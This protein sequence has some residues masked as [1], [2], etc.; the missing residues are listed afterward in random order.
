M[1]VSVRSSSLQRQ[2]RRPVPVRVVLADPEPLYLDSLARE[3]ERD[4][5]LELVACI[6]DAHRLAGGLRR[7][8]ADVAVVEAALVEPLL[9]FWR[10]SPTR[11]LVLA[12]ESGAPD[13]YAAVLRGAAGYLT[14]DAD[15]A[16]IRRAIAA[17][18]HGQAVLDAAAQTGLA[19][20]IRLR[21]PIDRPQ[22]SARERQVLGLIADGLTVARI[23]EA[24]ALS[25]ATV[26]THLLHVYE[27]LDV[28]DRAAAVA[29]AMRAGLLE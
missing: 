22:L 18:A 2:Q 25:G 1:P 17:V 6:S 9:A 21:T 4:R 19:A 29:V 8:A 3:V 14:K 7:L 16:R 10:P 28:S 24:L 11:L 13:P 23:A 5:A 27:K 26:K 12:S 15:G 20:E